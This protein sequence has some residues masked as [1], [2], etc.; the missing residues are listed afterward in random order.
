MHG[1]HWHWG[2]TGMPGDENDEIGIGF[3]IDSLCMD[4]PAIC[5]KKLVRGFLLQ[6][7]CTVSIQKM[8]KVV[9]DIFSRL[10]L[11]GADERDLH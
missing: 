7:G 2:G 5:F 3:L 8:E 4:Q 6:P 9:P 10:V 11:P 1:Q